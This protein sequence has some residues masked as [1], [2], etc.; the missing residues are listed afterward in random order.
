MILGFFVLILSIFAWAVGLFIS[1]LIM[2]YGYRIQVLAWSVVWIIQ[3]FSCVFYPLSALP[4]WAQPISRMLPT[5]Y[6][7]EGMRSVLSGETLPILITPLI[8]SI[9]FFIL[10]AIF[11]HRSVE[12]AKKKGLL[13]KNE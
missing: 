8:S 7:F 10:A 3:P 9:V 4:A 6:V 11:F 2:R 13:A 12:K 1:G 5:T